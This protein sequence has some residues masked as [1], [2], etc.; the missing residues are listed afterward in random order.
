MSGLGKQMRVKVAGEGENN[1]RLL[2]A[3]DDASC[4]ARLLPWLAPRFL[5]AFANALGDGIAVMAVIRPILEL[6][7]LVFSATCGMTAFCPIA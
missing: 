3:C 6:Q 5:D 7:Q 2:A 1:S 4:A